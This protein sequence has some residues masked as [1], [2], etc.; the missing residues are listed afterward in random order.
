[1]N[2][3]INLPVCAGL[4]LLAV[5]VGCS[6]PSHLAHKI[7]HTDQVLVLRRVGPHKAASV[8]IEGAKAK[9]IVEAV[10]SATRRE[11][12][13]STAFEDD[14]KIAFLR[15]SNPLAVVVCNR[16]R[17]SIDGCSYVDE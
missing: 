5:I 12:G 8:S 7:A 15:G 2:T 10:S 14:I 3:P 4:L 9:E 1:M 6:R 17:F 16:G 13:G 11:W